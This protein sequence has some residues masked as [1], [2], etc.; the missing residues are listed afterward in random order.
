MKICIRKMASVEKCVLCM[1]PIKSLLGY[2]NTKK[3][4][5]GFAHWA[6]WMHLLHDWSKKDPG[7][8]MGLG[9]P[10]NQN[11]QN[12]FKSD[13]CE[14]LVVTNPTQLERAQTYIVC[15]T[16]IFFTDCTVR[17]VLTWQLTVQFVRSYRWRGIGVA[18]WLGRC[19]WQVVE[20]HLDTWHIC[21]RMK[22]CHVAQSWAAMWYLSIGWRLEKLYGL[23]KSQT[24][25]LRSGWNVLGRAG[26]PAYPRWVLT[27]IVQ[28]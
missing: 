23:H 7:T 27:T 26:L 16:R 4:I 10:K 13:M 17:T 25:D 20:S 2:V 19:Y 3:M 14:G 6:M 12:H 24:R 5:R 22:W 18:C 1:Q 21:G 15:Q 11:S 28:I 9:R 8:K